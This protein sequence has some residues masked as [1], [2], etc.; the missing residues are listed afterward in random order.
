MMSVAVLLMVE[1]YLRPAE[2]LSLRRRSL[3][4]AAPGT[5]QAWSILLFPEHEKA[6][7]KTGESDDTVMING[8]RVAWMN[9]IWARLRANGGEDKLFLYTYARFYKMFVET[10]SR[11]TARRF[12][13]KAATAGSVSTELRASGHRRRRRR[14][15]DGGHRLL[16]AATRRPG[17]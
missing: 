3:L 17:D 2:L 7:S 11:R 15:A 10:A 5:R 12:P 4:P 14:E 9:P 16:C 8:R 13:T 6:R 1:C